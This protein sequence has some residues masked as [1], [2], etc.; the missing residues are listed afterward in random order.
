MEETHAYETKCTGCDTRNWCDTCA[1]SANEGVNPGDDVSEEAAFELDF[2]G[3]VSRTVLSL[4]DGDRVTGSRRRGAG[5]RVPSRGTDSW[6]RACAA[7]AEQMVWLSVSK[8][9]QE[10]FCFIN[11]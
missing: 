5:R 8:S 9:P 7:E 3:K 4:G 6:R 2:K 1:G 10:G 11:Q